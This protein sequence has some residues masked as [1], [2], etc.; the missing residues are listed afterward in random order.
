[1]VKKG[2]FKGLRISLGHSVIV[3]T[4]F[5]LSDDKYSCENDHYEGMKVPFGWYFKSGL[6]GKSLMEKDCAEVAG[7]MVYNRNVFIFI[8]DCKIPKDLGN[9]MFQSFFKDGTSRKH[10]KYIETLNKT[11]TMEVPEYRSDLCI[12][13]GDSVQNSTTNEFYS[14]FNF[15]LPDGTKFSIKKMK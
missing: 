9:T 12:G 5:L 15:S 13:I 4:K 2:H 8:K 14:E 3:C 1:M 7:I 11:T 6:Y 10:R